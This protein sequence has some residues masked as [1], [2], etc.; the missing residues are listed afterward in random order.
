MKNTIA[1]LI[2]L[3]CSFIGFSQNAKKS[4]P[5][6]IGYFSNY[7]FQPGAKIGTHF[8]L[9]NWETESENK[10]GTFTKS[11]SLYISPQIG[12]F[13]FVK[14]NTN[15]MVNADI[16]YRRIKSLKNRY[17]A[18]SLGLGYMN[19]SQITGVAVNLSD[20]SQEKQRTSSSYFLPTLNCEF[21]KFINSKI[22]WYSKFSYGLRLSP[23][24]KQTTM[25]FIELGTRVNLF[26][27]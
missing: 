1:I 5:I 11:K 2:F 6:S 15:F 18:F 20:G 23:N 19:R 9:K 27:S 25:F 16:G 10:K 4:I 17:S 26:G 14:N 24:E 21:G 7:G 3:S 8:D 13:S 22:G 12:F